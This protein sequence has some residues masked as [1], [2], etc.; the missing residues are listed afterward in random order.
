MNEQKEIKEVNL[1]Q[2]LSIFFQWIKKTFFSLV[3]I[4]GKS[5]Q[6]LYKY[7]WAT[8]IIIILSFAA[9]LYLSRPSVKRYKAEAMAVIHGSD[10][11]TVKEIC[12]QLE[13]AMA[14]NNNLSIAAKMGV[15]D[16]VSK[17]I[18]AIRTFDVIDYLADGSADK[19]DF[20][21]TH[22]L[23]DT[24]NVKM[25]DRV[26]IQIKT[27]NIA[28]VPIFQKALTR[29]FASNQILASQFEAQKKLFIDQIKICD[30]ELQRI[31]SLAKVMYFKDAKDQIKFENNKL[32]VGESRKQL[33]YGELLEINTRKSWAENN[34]AVCINPVDFPS[35][36]VVIA[37]P[38]NNRLLYSVIALFAGLVLSLFFAL[39]LNNLRSIIN[40]LENKSV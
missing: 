19:I 29:Y 23:E 9:G 8:I 21:H 11:Q 24:M 6:L 27:K 32:I 33:F 34:L 4:S 5:I 12:K 26:Y 15:P 1:L 35:G 37:N 36:F 13:Q 2:L 22:S 14:N 16:S 30:L 17:N 20:K 3:N 39:L 28:Q 7:K 40:F 25:K 18:L 10:A 31:D 38:I